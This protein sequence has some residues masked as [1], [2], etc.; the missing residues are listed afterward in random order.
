MGIDGVGWLV[1]NGFS[2]TGF[3]SGYFLVRMGF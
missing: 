1:K 2:S 3:F